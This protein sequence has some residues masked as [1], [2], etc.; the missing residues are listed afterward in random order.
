MG[1]GFPTANY[2]ADPLSIGGGGGSEFTECKA[3]RAVF[4]R[5]MGFWFNKL[6]LQAIR[7]TYTDDTESKT[8]G[9]EHNDYKEL[10]LGDKETI[11]RATLWGNGTGVRAG[12]IELDTNGG[13]N[14]WAGK[15]VKGQQMYPVKTGSG[16]LAG[17]CGRSGYDIDMLCLIFLRPVARIE[18]SDFKY[19]N[20]KSGPELSK[21]GIEKKSLKTTTFENKTATDKAWKFSEAVSVTDTYS[22]SNT[23]T[24]QVGAK[25]GGK[26][27]GTLEAGI[28]MVT[29]A[30]IG[31]E[32]STEANYSYTTS[33]QKT[34]LKTYTHTLTWELSG[35][36]KQGDK[37]IL[38]TGWAT[39][40]TRDFD[41][42]AKTVLVFEN[43]DARL[44]FEEKGK[45]SVVQWTDA[46][47]DA[48]DAKEIPN[49]PAM[50]HSAAAAPTENKEAIAS[51][52]EE[53]PAPAMLQ[54]AAPVDRE[55]IASNSEES[56]APA[57]LQSA[58]PVE[59]GEAPSPD[60]SSQPPAQDQPAPSLTQR[61]LP[62]SFLLPYGMNI[63][64][65]LTTV[66][67]LQT[68]ALKSFVAPIFASYQGSSSLFVK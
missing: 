13:Q 15:D 18:T 64:G 27:S 28:P 49:E 21:Q 31:W 46:F 58:A 66:T 12:R 8:Y 36:M 9:T 30:K 3:D 63:F 26:M 7:I 68:M 55:A 2:F 38:C 54:S 53:T 43:P 41:Y 56:P 11:T 59:T 25:L 22:I 67:D 14:F 32:V 50:L 62:P 45:M 65:E 10:T 16:I 57:M 29:T 17:L 48:D 33:E 60:T 34:D 23:K 44:P 4:V 39:H 1:Y 24:H 61:K 37:P 20:L 40:G 42:T 47:A 35:T 51:D 19:T 6:G 5:K 52:S